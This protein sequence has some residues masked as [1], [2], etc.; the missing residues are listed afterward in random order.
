MADYYHESNYYPPFF[1]RTGQ[2]LLATQ[3]T[4]EYANGDI[5]HG[6]KLRKGV[7]V[8]DSIFSH[9]DEFDEDA[10]PTATAKVRLHDGST[11]VNLIALDATQLGT[12]NGG[13][14]R[15]NQVAN[16]GYLVQADGFEL[17]LVLDAAVAN[18]KTAIV[19]FG[20]FISTALWG[21]DQVTVET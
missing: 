15:H 3:A 14:V 2:W 19:K 13:V 10:S 17:Q 1:P 12:A 11:A 20:V 16:L 21:A 8:L 5:V 7:W 9:S 6:P 4:R 18:P